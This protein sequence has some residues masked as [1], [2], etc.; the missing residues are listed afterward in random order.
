MSATQT[1]Y[2]EG[3][4][5]FK[6]GLDFSW[7]PYPKGTQQWFDWAEGWTDHEHHDADKDD[8]LNSIGWFG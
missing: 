5:A 8:A 7:N 6:K 2:G 3:F 1:A 4:S